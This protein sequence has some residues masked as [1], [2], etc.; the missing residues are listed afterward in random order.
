[1]QIDA[2]LSDELQACYGFIAMPVFV[3]GLLNNFMFSPM[4]F[5][6]SRLWENNQI[7]AF[8]K[9]IWRQILIII[10]ITVICMSAAWVCGIPVLSWLYHT[11]LSAYKKELLVMLL[12]GGFLGISGFFQVIL[13]IMRNNREL[14]GGYAA[15]AVIAFAF[16]D[17]VV[18]TFGMMGAA[19]FYA[20]LMLTLCVIFGVVFLERV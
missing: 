7:N 12:G 6:M 18:R 9:R 10:M 11:D 1:M 20:G 19:L 13:T 4:I 3:I 17:R 14:L 8:R 15:A 2:V 16:S 5:Q